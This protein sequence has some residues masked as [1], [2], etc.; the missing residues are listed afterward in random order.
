MSEIYKIGVIGVG[1]IGMVHVSTYTGM[2]NC[3]IVSISDVNEENLKTCTD[4]YPVG[5]TYTDYNEMLKKEDLDIVSVCTPHYLHCKHTVDALESDAHVICEKPMAVNL[6]EADQMLKASKKAGKE[7]TVI[8]N[9]RYN[10]Y[11]QTTRKLIESGE[12]GDLRYIKGGYL[13]DMLLSDT[14]TEG[15]DWLWDYRRSGG[16]ILMYIGPHVFC[17]SRYLAG[18]DV[19]WVFAN[20]ERNL[21]F[22]VEDWSSTYMHFKNGV[23]AILEHSNVGKYNEFHIDCIGT[24]GATN[25]TQFLH[26]GMDKGD[27]SVKSGEKLVHSSIKINWKQYPILDTEEEVVIGHPADVWKTHFEDFI[28][29]IETGERPIASA[30]DGRASLEVI[31]AT[32]E[33]Q[34]QGRKVKLPLAKKTNPLVELMERDEF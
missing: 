11:Y 3:E 17:L 20:V 21:G 23:N 34:L 4:A 32:Y 25:V 29:S 27:Y 28:N 6:G 8:S 33:S 13:A 9:R 7:L 5:N 24:E 2:E 10:S 1:F 12:I 26:T 19:D 31:M 22:D 18:S 16:G 30:E 14:L 15:G